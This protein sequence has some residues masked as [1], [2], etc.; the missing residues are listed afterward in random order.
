VNSTNLFAHCG[1]LQVCPFDHPRRELHNLPRG[2]TLYRPSSGAAEV[3]INDNH[4]LETESQRAFFQII[5]AP[6]FFQPGAHLLHR[7]LADVD[8]GI[9]FNVTRLDLLA[10][11]APPLCWLG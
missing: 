8:V 6:L 11:C 1:K 7:R 4:A 3:F 9:A 10:H 2:K 5:L